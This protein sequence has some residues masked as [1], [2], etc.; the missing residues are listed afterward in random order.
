MCYCRH[1]KQHMDQSCK[2]KVPVEGTCIVLGNGA[3]FFTRRG[4]AQHKT[5]QEL[6]E[7]LEM[8]HT[9]KLTHITDNIRNKHIYLQLLS[10]LL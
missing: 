5:Q 2:K 7:I 4:F 9:M 3:R 1:K 8:A 10:L 6:L